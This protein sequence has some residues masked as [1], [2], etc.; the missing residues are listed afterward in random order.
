LKGIHDM[1]ANV[2]T[3]LFEQLNRIAHV[4]PSPPFEGFS[5]FIVR[6]LGQPFRLVV[7]PNGQRNPTISQTATLIERVHIAYD[8][9]AAY[10]SEW[11]SAV[12]RARLID[13]HVPFV[14]PSRQLYL[15]FLGF[16]LRNDGGHRTYKRLGKPAQRLLLA[17]LRTGFRGPMTDLVALRM[18]ECSR[19]TVFRVF[20]ELEF[21]GLLLRENGKCM[22]VDDLAEAISDAQPQ[23]MTSLTSQQL[24]NNIQQRY[25]QSQWQ[26]NTDTNSADPTK[27]R[28]SVTTT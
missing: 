23:L 22:L 15:P 24:L 1:K 28:D 10:C 3:Y 21:F 5:T 25:A 2:E 27:P 8:M 26:Q 6:G 11:L 12:E 17:A 19:A 14:L 16:A 20:N 18:A 7:P 9:P 13:R 4:Q